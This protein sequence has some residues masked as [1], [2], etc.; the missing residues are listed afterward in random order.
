[1]NG[2]FH[3]EDLRQISEA[4]DQAFL[5]LSASMTSPTVYIAYNFHGLIHIPVQRRQPVFIG[6]QLQA[7]VPKCFSF[8]FFF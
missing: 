5:P 7:L 4:T 6:T 1:M 2:T 3:K 8:L